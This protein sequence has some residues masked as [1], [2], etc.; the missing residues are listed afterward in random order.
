M[1]HVGTLVV[2]ALVL[3]GLGCAGKQV[4]QHSGYK[5]KK[6]TPWTKA[7]AI[8]LDDENKAKVSGELDYAEYKRAK[9]Y[10]LAL[11]GSGT[12]DLDFEA[13]PG[14]DADMDVAFE[15]FDPNNKVLVR[16]D[17]DA[18]DVNE[19]KK[20]RKLEDLDEGTYLIHVYLQGRLDTADFDLKLKFTRGQRPRKS[21]FPAQVPFPDE[22]AAVPPVDDTPSKAPEPTCGVKGKP[23]CKPRCGVP[24]KPSCSK[25]PPPPP[26]CGGS[27]QPPCKLPPLA[28]SITNVDPDPSGSRIT[29]AAGTADGVTN[30]MRGSVPGVK[31]SSFSV[32]GCTAQRCSAVVKAAVDD[33]RS[34][35]EVRITR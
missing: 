13:V 15:V 3:G 12:L 35:G 30:G 28:A 29:I 5:G 31:G 22:L 33:V 14:G 25:P 19:Q 20:Q 6:P 27:G 7:K 17:A 34:A 11:P 10:S 4:P 26:P 24:G 9:W 23:R 21:D 32:S 18:D 2:L 16:A 8:E 1:R